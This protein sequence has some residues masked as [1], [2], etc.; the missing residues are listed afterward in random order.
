[1][2]AQPSQLHMYSVAIQR[3]NGQLECCSPIYRL[4]SILH[5]RA[6]H[7]Q[8]KIKA[9]KEKQDVPQAVAP[10]AVSFSAESISIKLPSA[11]LS[12]DCIPRSSSPEPVPSAL[13]Y[14]WPC[15]PVVANVQHM[16]HKCLCGYS[17]SIQTS[18]YL[19]GLY[20]HSELGAV[21]AAVACEVCRPI[22]R[23]LAIRR[24]NY[25]TLYIP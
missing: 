6:R 19:H 1:L 7:Y 10:Q 23:E 13:P 17:M 2:M 21:Q 18:W 16:R 8:V 20:R 15:T 11:Y 4:S 14:Q 12:W 3:Q 24:L 22:R 9:L 5:L 25:V